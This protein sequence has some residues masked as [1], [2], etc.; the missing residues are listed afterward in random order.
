V[1]VLNKREAK[2]PRSN[3]MEDEGIGVANSFGSVVPLYFHDQM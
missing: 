2:F 3:S 1:E